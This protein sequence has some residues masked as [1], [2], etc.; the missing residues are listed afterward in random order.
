MKKSA[1]FF[2][3]SVL[4]VTCLWKFSGAQVP[5]T[6]PEGFTYQAEARDR[7]GDLLAQQKLS[8][9]IIIF[10]DAIGG[11]IVWRESRQVETNDYG[12][13]T[14]LIGKGTSKYT[15]SEIKWGKHLHFL[16]VAIKRL[17]DTKWINMGTS[18]L[19]SVPYAFHS[20]TANKI[21]SLAEDPYVEELDRRIKRLEKLPP[22]DTILDLR[23]NKSYPCV[24]IGHQVWM[25][26]NLA[27][28]APGSVVYDNDETYEPVYGRL[29]DWPTVMNGA[30]SSSANPSGV[31]GVC[32]D[33]WHV[34]SW[35]EWNQLKEYLAVYGYE[36][37]E[38]IVL[39][40]TIGWLEEGGI[41]GTN[42][43][44]FNARAGGY[45][46]RANNFDDYNNIN[47]SGYWWTSSGLSG[48]KARHWYMRYDFNSLYDG[49]YM[50]NEDYL[51]VRC[52]KD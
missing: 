31:Q 33:G 14:F 13:F 32:P 16:N 3:I 42:I 26:E 52:V 2:I 48:D 30:E 15:F 51:S 10:Q 36:W 23:D 19:L 37:D 44:G 9:R 41:K 17:V 12:M 34:P 40:D 22:P 25:A 46:S 11:P 39:K 35:S 27:Y 43:F 8:V 28:N 24:S 49:D 47:N 1:S 20:K 45:L 38:G 18:Q 50:S 29:Y 4:L 5:G 7:I 21:I 6:P